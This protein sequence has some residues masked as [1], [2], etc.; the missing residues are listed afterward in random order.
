VKPRKYPENT[1]KCCVITASP[2]SKRSPVV[3]ANV[4]A[5]AAAAQ[6]A[7]GLIAARDAQTGRDFPAQTGFGF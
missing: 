2:S 7:R 6:L 3:P 4:R 5:E 1:A